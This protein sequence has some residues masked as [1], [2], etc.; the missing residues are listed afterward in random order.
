MFDA[1]VM[2]RG[3][4]VTVTRAYNPMRF[5]TEYVVEVH[6]TERNIRGRRS[7]FDGMGSAEAGMRVQLRKVAHQ[8]ALKIEA[9]CWTPATTRLVIDHLVAWARQVVAS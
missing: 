1:W 7:V 9:T 4:K 2:N 8:L 6:D 3:Y 5:E